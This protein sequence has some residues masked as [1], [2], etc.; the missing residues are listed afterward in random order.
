MKT[1]FQVG[2]RVMIVESGNPRLVGLEGTVR[3]PIDDGGWIGVV[4]DTEIA[5]GHDLD[6]MCESGYGW[7]FPSHK[8][9][10]IPVLETLDIK[11][12]EFSALIGF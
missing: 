9:K 8:A 6:G 2:D 11:Q 4:F 5:C 1:E 10:I 12:D 7:Y 3:V